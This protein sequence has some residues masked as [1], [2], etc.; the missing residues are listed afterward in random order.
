M[1]DSGTIK[2]SRTSTICD[3]DYAGKID[4]YFQL[5]LYTYMELNIFLTCAS[6]N[7]YILPN[8]CRIST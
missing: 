7:V 6:R 3:C 4:D 2:H 8:T 5:N 1:I